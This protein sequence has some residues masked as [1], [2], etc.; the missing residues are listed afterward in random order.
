MKSGP[1]YS[2][3][4]LS[5]LNEAL[6]SIDKDAYPDRVEA[7][8]NA[9]FNYEPSNPSADQKIENHK[10]NGTLA[11]RNSRIAA[12]IIDSIIAII[13]V[14]PSIIV[15]APNAFTQGYTL[16]QFAVLFIYGLV[17]FFILNGFLL[18]HY[19]QTIGKRLLNIRIE[20]LDGN[21]ASVTT[22]YF[23]RILPMQVAT[24]IPILNIVIM[25]TN[26]VCFF[27]KDRR[28]LHD[29]IAGTRV[30]N[31]AHNKSQQSDD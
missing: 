16:S 15:I 7:I 27:R 28:A 23:K 14:I 22:I 11:N 26:T 30:T 21:K 18:H 24:Q 20:A 13:S 12:A 8:N 1:D 6:N 9:I 17:T 5:E 25:L 10:E 4:S 19:G 2:R 31:W 3:Y 29:H